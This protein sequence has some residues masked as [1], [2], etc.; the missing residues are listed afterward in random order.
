M[1]KGGV[2]AEERVTKSKGRDY[3]SQEIK[4]AISRTQ[5]SILKIIEGC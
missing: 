2:G 4:M 3:S 5:Q 1:F